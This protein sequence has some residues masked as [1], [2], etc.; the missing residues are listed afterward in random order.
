[1]TALLFRPW[2]QGQPIHLHQPIKVEPDGTRIHFFPRRSLGSAEFLLQGQYLDHRLLE[3]GAAQGP[4]VLDGFALLPAHWSAAGGTALP[5]VTLQPGTG[6]TLDGRAVRLTASVTVAWADLVAIRARVPGAPAALADGAYLLTVQPIAFETVHGPPPDPRDRNDIDPTL[7]ERRDSFVEVLLSAPV[8]APVPVPPAAAGAADIALYLN[9]VAAGLSLSQLAAIAAG[10]LP[11]GLVLVLGGAPVVISAASGRLPA[12]PAGLRG[13]LLA[14]VR[15]TLALAVAAHGPTPFTAADLAAIRGQVRFVPAA[16]ELPLTFLLQPAAVTASCP[17]W[18]TGM[19]VDLATIRVSEARGVIARELTRAP[20]DLQSPT[21]DGVLLLLAVPDQ[22]WQ[23]DLLDLPRADPLLP[24]DLFQAF[25]AAATG[26]IAAHHAWSAL[27]GGLGSHASDANRRTLNFLRLAV[28][29]PN[30]LTVLLQQPDAPFLALLDAAGA[31][32]GVTAWLTQQA[33][34]TPD[35]PDANTLTTQLAADGYRVLDSEPAAPVAPDL[36]LRPLVRALPANSAYQDW[37]HATNTTDPTDDSN[38]ASEGALLRLILLHTMQAILALAARRLEILLN[39][40]DRLIALQRAHLD[41]L[42]SYGSALAGGVP[43]DGKGMQVARMLPFIRLTPTPPASGSQTVAPAL[44]ALPPRMAPRSASTA[45]TERA[46]ARGIQINGT[47]PSGPG[48]TRVPVNV[49]GSAA[50]SLLGRGQDAAA[51]VADQ[52]GAISTEPQFQFQPQNYGA[53]AHVTPADSALQVLQRGRDN[54]IDLARQINLTVPAATA[55]PAPPA[56]MDAEHVA[57]SNMLI[58]GRDLLA[59]IDAAERNSQ[60]IEARYRI[61]RDRLTAL[62]AAIDAAQRDVDYGRRAVIDAIRAAAAPAGDYASAQRLVQ[63]E[64]DRIAAATVK[65]SKVLGDAV[66]LFYVRTRQ[67]PVLTDLPA[68]RPLVAADPGDLVPG[69]A[70]DH[71]GPPAVVQPFLDWV[72]ELPLWDFRPVRPLWPYLPDRSGLSRLVSSRAAR[73]AD[74]SPSL[75]DA[76]AFGGGPAAPDLLALH[77]VNQGVFTAQLRTLSLMMSDSLA[78]TQRAAALVFAVP[79]ILPLPANP[80]RLAIEAF[81]RRIE[82]ASGC[83]AERLNALP[84]STRFA[85]YE[86]ARAGTL[87]ALA[88]EQWPLVGVDT[89]DAFTTHRGIAA[90]VTWLAGQLADAP[91]TAAVPALANLVRALV[92]AAA[93]GDPQQVL[94]G[95]VTAATPGFRIGDP[96]RA[97]LNRPPAIGTLLHVFDAT[98]TLIGTVSVEDNDANGTATRLVASFR[99]DIVDVSGFTLA[100]AAT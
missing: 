73:L 88:P 9:R 18:P 43:A 22:E 45:A 50:G 79:D 13:L 35:P 59:Q 11:V 36:V 39:G 4:G 57:Y 68:P 64:V 60:I 93:H 71:D 34:A 69:C 44:A 87:P 17:F 85:L 76:A 72:L 30:T 3:L 92:I 75:L 16:G 78:E 56:G 97:V 8:P 7:D 28:G 42:S 99:T 20:I 83:V 26:F 51:N 32:D 5:P 91:S 58:V 33:I 86:Q 38:P 41:T 81:R 48:R 98:R 40:H 65:R 37:L 90:L 54:L 10:T 95:S 19:D 6:V 15:E 61:Y 53:A 84:P 82:A 63:E 96:V 89:T 2:P 12:A 31:I 46:A 55:F 67:T 100:A 14:Q 21:E 52:L 94:S 70:A 62:A 27:Y 23:S 1:M 29:D 66:G 74:R 24:A 77:Q 47:A 25:V 49:T 80:L